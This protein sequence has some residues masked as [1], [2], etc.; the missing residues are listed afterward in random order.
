MVVKPGTAGEVSYYEAAKSG[1]TSA[2]RS[3]GR[4]RAHGG[5]GKGGDVAVTWSRAQSPVDER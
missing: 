1:V 4:A 2:V 5:R 3:S